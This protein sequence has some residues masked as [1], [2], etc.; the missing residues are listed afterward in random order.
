MKH[1][2]IL[3]VV[4]SLNGYEAGPKSLGISY[5]DDVGFYTETT[6]KLQIIIRTITDFVKN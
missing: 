1:E 5:L 2:G 3:A 6:E 4:E